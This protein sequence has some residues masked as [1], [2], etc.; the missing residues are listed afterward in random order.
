M[1]MFT[2]VTVLIKDTNTLMFPILQVSSKIY[3][4]SI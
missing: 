1:I 3:I 4:V 2:H